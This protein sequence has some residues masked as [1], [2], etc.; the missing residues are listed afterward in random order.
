MFS[1]P[2]CYNG[3]HVKQK[4]S[5]TSY[6]FVFRLSNIFRSSPLV[7]YYLAVFD[8]LIQRSFL[9]NAKRFL[10]YSKNY[11]KYLGE[12]SLIICCTDSQDNYAK[13]IGR[14]NNNNNPKVSGRHI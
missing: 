2:V 7:M 4:G 14:Q 1:N 13:S 8:A 9:L 3:S 10:S 12:D 5:G 6:Q 11:M